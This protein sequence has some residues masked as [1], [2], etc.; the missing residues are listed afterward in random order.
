MHSVAEATLRR[1]MTSSCQA[2]ATVVFSTCVVA[3]QAG[4]GG[5]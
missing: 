1:L 3:G 5:S 4:G 2:R